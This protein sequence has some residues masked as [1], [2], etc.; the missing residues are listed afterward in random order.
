MPQYS[1]EDPILVDNDVSALRTDFVRLRKERNLSQQHV[2]ALL[3]QTQASLSNF[4]QGKGTPRKSTLYQIRQ[5]VNVWQ[6]ESANVFSLPAKPTKPTF[7]CPRCFKS[8]LSANDGAFFCSYCK[9]EFEVNCSCGKT[10]TGS[11]SYCSNCGRPVYR[12]ATPELLAS[13]SESTVELA[14]HVLLHRLFQWLDDEQVMEQITEAIRRQDLVKDRIDSDQTTNVI[15][16]DPSE[17]PDRGDNL[18]TS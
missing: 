6:S 8:V 17:V 18:A 15:E 13:K 16:S 5:L 7:V 10:N 2:A 1:P 9:F 14:R 11:S 3:G 4:E 12:D